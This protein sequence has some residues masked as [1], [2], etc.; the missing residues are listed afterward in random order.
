MDKSGEVDCNGSEHHPKRKK[1]VKGNKP[2]LIA[3]I[4]NTDY[5]IVKKVLKDTMKC[6]LS[7]E[8]ENN[9]A[10]STK[11]WDIYWNDI[12]IT[13]ELLSKM[14]PYQKVNHLP[15]MEALSRKNLLGKHLNRMKKFYPKEYSF[16]PPTWLLPSDF[17]EFKRQFQK[18][19]NK[20][21]IVK[22]EAKSQGKGIR[23]IKSWAGIKHG[24]HCVVQQYIDKPFL[25][26]G[27]KFDLRIYVLVYGCD[28]YRIYMHKEGLARLATEQYIAPKSSNIKNT[29]MHL[30]NYAI[31]KNNAHFE[32]NMEANNA[33]VGHKR[34]LQFVWDHINKNGGDAAKVKRK[35]KNCIVKAF[36]MVQPLL[37]H[38]YK[39]CQP[40][41]FAN[42]KCF[43]I[44]GFD[45]LLDYKFKPWLL[46][47][48]QAP[49]FST[50]T[51]FDK[52][53]KAELLE[54]TFKLINLN[55]DKKISYN[56]KKNAIQQVRLIK[57][58]YA[59]KKLRIE[60]RKE[61]KMKKM[62]K[63]DEYELNHLGNYEVAYP[64]K[65][66]EEEYEK[67]IKTASELWD[68]FT[69]GKK[70]VFKESIKK[71]SQIG[72]KVIKNELSLMRPP[73]TIPIKNIVPENK[74][75]VAKIRNEISIKES[76]YSDK[77]TPSATFQ[78]LSMHHFEN[79][80]K[81]I[82]TEQHHTL[83][84]PIASRPNKTEHKQKRDEFNIGKGLR[85]AY[86]EV[87]K[88]TIDKYNKVL[89]ITSNKDIWR[90]DNYGI[91]VAPKIMEFTNHPIPTQTKIPI[92]YKKLVAQH[93][94]SINF[95]KHF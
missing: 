23:L 15:G 85:S 55:L 1:G 3:N 39:S 19:K 54:D 18:N 66:F 47:V 44:L 32:Y 8:V 73:K 80:V 93:K 49:S 64:D 65:E 28:P 41:D 38:I 11:D 89:D 34:S 77:K 10:V 5:S 88:T 92:I 30:T 12:S 35:I 94:I 29:F 9:D 16:F 21:F 56:K 7:Y 60:E 2:V 84:K 67:Y 62:A 87:N 53:V 13:P 36:C 46:E 50:D 42:N 26:E 6:K 4:L 27:L 91:Y 33:E 37:A 69:R 78:N 22:P 82:E 72:R 81:K 48:N 90:Q 70:K 45:I 95:P 20:V 51:P 59:N 68:L 76:T 75:F 57:Y 40:N 86:E 31:N 74:S 79:Y 61:I 43:E 25:I 14:K 52:K 58:K 24:E 71:V 83:Y 63:R 17:A